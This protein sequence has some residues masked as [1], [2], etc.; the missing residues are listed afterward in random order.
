MINNALEQVKLADE[1]GYDYVWSTEH[2]FLEEYSHSSAP[3]MFLTACAM[4]TK[5]IRLGHGIVVCVPEYSSPIRIAERTAML[6]IP[7][8]AGSTLAP[9]ARPPGPSW[10]AWAPTST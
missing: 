9:A 1:L 6:D 3:E 10:R 5:R 7:P 2:H 8:A 4:V